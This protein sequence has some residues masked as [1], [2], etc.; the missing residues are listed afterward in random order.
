MTLAHID[1]VWF[2]SAIGAIIF[3]VLFPL[4]LAFII[5]RRLKVGW[6]YFWFGALVFFVCQL[7][8]RVPAVQVIQ[9][10]ISPQ[11]QASPAL[12]WGWLFIL[13]L[14]AGLFEEVGRYLGYRIFMRSE[15]KTWNKAVMYGTG[16]GGLESMLLV[17]GLGA[18]TLV[19][20][21]LIPTLNLSSLPTEQQ[22]QIVDQ[23]AA[24][25]AQ[26]GWLPLLGAYERLCAIT[27]QIA[28][29]VVVVQVFRR[30]QIRWLWIAVLAHFAFDFAA[31]GVAQ[32]LPLIGMSDA[33]VI[34]L[35]AEGVVSI[36]ALV[37]LWTIFVLRDKP[38]APS[39]VA[40]PA[41]AP[42]DTEMTGPE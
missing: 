1:T 26:P 4:V 3:N 29:S 24:I 25:A 8:L 5:S 11:L 17:A 19:N 22:R 23:F 10:F 27:A 6:R 30:R 9:A 33:T 12:L 2:A 13:A 7:I 28:L 18:L 41:S 40:E 42:P 16:H 15:E 21:F 34:A 20:L 31:V 39:Q 14:T 36:G 38:A 37:A 35:A 32:G